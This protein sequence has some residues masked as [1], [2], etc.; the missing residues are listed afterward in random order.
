MIVESAFILSCL[1]GGSVLIRILGIKG[2]GVPALGFLVGLCLYVTLGSLLLALSIETSPLLQ[3]ALVGI[4]PLAVWYLFLSRGFD[5]K[6][7]TFYCLVALILSVLLVMFFRQA[8]FI[9]WSVDTL[10][11]LQLGSLIATGNYTATAPE[12]MVQLPLALPIINTPANI[13]EQYYLRS[14]VPLIGLST[15]LTFSWI[16]Y[17][18]IRNE[19]EKK[20]AVIYTITGAILLLSVNRFIFS[21]FYINNHILFAGLILIVVGCGWLLTKKISGLNDVKLITLQLII[22]PTLVLTRPEAPL[23]VA[24]SILPTLFIHRLP[25]KIRRVPLL[26]LGLSTIALQVFLIIQHLDQGASLPFSVIGMLAFGAV[27]V[28]TAYLVKAE[29]LK[30]R[31]KSI[32]SFTEYGIWISLVFLALINHRSIFKSLNSVTQNLFLG[33]GSW[34]LSIIMFIGLMLWLNTTRRAKGS[35]ALRIPITT[36]VPLMFIIAFLRGGGYRVGNGDSL[37]RAIVHILPV[38]VLHVVVLTAI[39]VDRPWFKKL[40]KKLFV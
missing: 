6:M 33:E 16:L 38:L 12:R 17:T 39:G 28:A 36:F 18:G 40:K 32:I 29:W 19:M 22:L 13:I 31:F 23:I 26:A 27:C 25:W 37:N 15:I 1:V 9:N 30:R 5:V 35:V 7:N 10:A 2:W 14:V 3:I 8:N 21:S 4:L 20:F 34:G 24:F 11:H